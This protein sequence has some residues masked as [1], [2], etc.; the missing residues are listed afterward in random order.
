MMEVVLAL[1]QKTLVTVF[2]GW[3][4]PM[5]EARKAI[6]NEENIWRCNNCRLA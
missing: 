4:R 2:R 5:V 6:N 3:L 1:L